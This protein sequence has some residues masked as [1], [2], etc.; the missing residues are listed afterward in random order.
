MFRVSSARK[1]V[2]ALLLV[3]GHFGTAAEPDASTLIN[4]GHYKHARVVLEKKLAANPNDAQSLAQMALVKI[5]FNDFDAA[6]KLAEQSVKLNPRDAEAHAVLAESYGGK[7][8]GDVGM[9]EGFRLA[10]ATKSEAETALA[11]DPNNHLA[12]RTLMEFY[13]D[14]PGLIGGSNSN[15]EGIAAKI[16][17]IDPAKGYLA[18]AEIATKE[19]HSDQLETLYQKAVEADPRN[20]NAL[21]DLGWLY[22]AE[23][24]LDLA[25]ADNCAQKAIQLD[26]TRGPGWALSAIVK[27]Q[28]GDL[29]GL[30]K[31]LAQAE[32]AAPDNLAYYFRAARVLSGAGKDDIRAEKFFKRYLSQEPEAGAPTLALAHWQYGLLLQK[33]GRG[34]ESVEEL[35]TA[36]SM[37][38]NLKG[39]KEDL[40]RALHQK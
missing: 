6:I 26:P 4:N 21:M 33:N 37:D 28:M 7:A 35:Q 23:N 18:K 22:V 15:A 1:M 36:V 8:S 25:K 12:L 20:Y 40:K 30:D 29:P 9:I 19:N 39:A 14:A 11:I 27:V 38:P 13:L 16:L 5:A 31:L 3:A 17:T 34:M 10:R 32:K 2:L 24:T